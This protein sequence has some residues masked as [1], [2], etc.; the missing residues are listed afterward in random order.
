MSIILDALKKSDSE[1]QRQ[2]TP[3]I[4][5][6]PSG[7]A[8]KSG[9][10]WTWIIGVL[11]LLNLIA[12]VFLINRPTDEPAAA[13]TPSAEPAAVQ[14]GPAPAAAEPVTTAQGPRT[15]PTTRP[16]IVEAA[17]QAKPEPEP[18]APTV[19]KPVEA[20][21]PRPTVTAGLPT[22]DELRARGVLQLP[23]LHVDIHVF[24][25]K[26]DDRFVFVNMSKYKERA[27]LAEGPVISE[28]TPDGVVLD[29]LGTAFL[30]PRE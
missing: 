28:I 19:E 21:A 17:P 27:R 18:P 13:A 3:G 29:Y 12:V 25:G 22:F 30:L 9:A 6:I 1:R 8:G 4:A 16:E 10:R 14:P 11:L 7:Q 24:S 2:N 23:D 15:D 5:S 26:P 20:P